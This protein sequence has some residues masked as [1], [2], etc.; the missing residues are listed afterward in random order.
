MYSKKIG[1]LKENIVYNNPK[2]LYFILLYNTFFNQVFC[3]VF[4]EKKNCFS[5]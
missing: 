2:K 3:A 5:Q 4:L 1:E